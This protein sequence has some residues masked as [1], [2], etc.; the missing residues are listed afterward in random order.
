MRIA[1]SFSAWVPAGFPHPELTARARARAAFAPASLAPLTLNGAHHCIVVSRPRLG[2]AGLTTLAMAK[3]GGKKK[4]GGKK[5]AAPGAGAGKGMG[6]SA[7]TPTQKTSAPAKA[8]A[9][10][11]AAAAAPPAHAEGDKVTGKGKAKAGAVVPK[12]ALVDDTGEPDSGALEKA[13]AI[14][15]ANRGTLGDGLGFGGGKPAHITGEDGVMRAVPE[16]WLYGI[17]GD[18]QV[19]GATSKGVTVRLTGKFWR[20]RQWAFDSIVE[21]FAAEMPSHKVYIEEGGQL[22]DL[23]LRD[24]FYDDEAWRVR[25]EGPQ[26]VNERGIQ[27]AQPFKADGSLK[28]FDEGA[29]QAGI[30]EM[31]VDAMQQS[32]G[33][34]LDSKSVD[35]I[36]QDMAQ[37]KDGGGQYSA[38]GGA[39]KKGQT[40]KDGA[41]AAAAAA[42]SRATEDKIRASIARGEVPGIDSVVG[43]SIGEDGDVQTPEVVAGGTGEPAATPA[44]AIQGNPMFEKMADMLEGEPEVVEE[45]MAMLD[46]SNGNMFALMTN[47]KFQKLAQKMMSNPELM[48]MMS[49]PTLVKDA[50]KSAE[51]IGLTQ[52]MGIKP[53]GNAAEDAG[54]FAK[55]ATEAIKQGLAGME[56]EA[57]AAAAAAAADDESMPE[58]LRARV[59]KVDDALSRMSKEENDD[60]SVLDR[61]G[62]KKDFRK[63][64]EE[65]QADALRAAAEEARERERD[66]LFS[67]GS[68]GDSVE[69]MRALLEESREVATASGGKV[70]EVDNSE[71]L[72]YAGGFVVGVGGVLF[73]IAVAI[74]LIDSPF[75]ESPGGVVTP[76]ARRVQQSAPASSK[77]APQLK[78]VQLNDDPF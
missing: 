4:G 36:N 65:K 35:E 11:T 15:E 25:K 45:M 68:G 1:A 74:G 27:V 6:A 14:L 5:A 31:M 38:P 18:A 24:V 66:A 8:A 39:L 52:Q 72:L 9:A 28:E 51:Q 60:T 30:E 17:D 37:Q 42:E 58:V 7:A 19:V 12:A 20:S 63:V 62:V 77:D 2:G 54:A 43:V 10:V 29:L 41:A 13:R 48:Q 16:N 44:T 21:L 47:P 69:D 57:A 70:G 34:F 49:D 59:G 55:G 3:K 67:G 50:M 26:Y 76:A 71:T 33:T 61:L 32:A 40:A 75:P 53:S 73:G 23:Y 78:A 56:A 64:R 46:K 22:A